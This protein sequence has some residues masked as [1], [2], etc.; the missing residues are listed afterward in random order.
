M[1]H[2]NRNWQRR[3]TVDREAKCA[4]HQTGLVAR[5]ALSPIGE[6]SVTFE[7]TDEALASL[8]A[9]A[10]RRPAESLNR[11]G[12]EALTLGQKLMRTPNSK[13]A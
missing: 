10:D 13:G 6:V 12:D 5:Y 4:V 2:R 8:T 1:A 11:L 9:A 7:N 3:W